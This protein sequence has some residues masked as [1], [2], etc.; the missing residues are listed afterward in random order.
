MIFDRAKQLFEMQTKAR[1]LKKELKNVLVSEEALSGKIKVVVSGE[2]KIQE[3]TI[4][5]ELLTPAEKSNLELFLKNALNSALSKAQ[6]EA[7]NRMKEVTGDL[8]FS[9]LLGGKG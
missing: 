9:S 2:Q 6:E 3:I 4:S 1:R 5:E 7:T 8:D